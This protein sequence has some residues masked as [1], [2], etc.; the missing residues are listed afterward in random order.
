MF[1][2]IERNDHAQLEKLLQ[3]DVTQQECQREDRHYSAYTYA[4]QQGATECFKLLYKHGVKQAKSE[5]SFKKS[6]IAE[7]QLDCLFHTIQ[8]NNF[9]LLRF[10]V[11]DVKIDL[12]SIKDKDVC[13][14]IHVAAKHGNDLMIY[15][16][17]EMGADVNAPDN[18]GN[19]PLHVAVLNNREHS[20]NFLISMGAELQTVNSDG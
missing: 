13:H 15:M 8:A 1:R 9:E 17:G 6:W 2:I 11:N 16:I 7:E 4:C 18:R 5:A 12:N 19:T 10:L 14:A 20:V 3:S